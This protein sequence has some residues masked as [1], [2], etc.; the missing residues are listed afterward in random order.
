MVALR[1]NDESP[2]VIRR[3]ASTMDAL[4]GRVS[5]SVADQEDVRSFVVLMEFNE[6]CVER[7]RGYEGVQLCEDAVQCSKYPARYR[8]SLPC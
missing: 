4:I 2:M 8:Y 5:D 6:S 1:P 3:M 7:D